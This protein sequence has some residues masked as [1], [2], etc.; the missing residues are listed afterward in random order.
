VL[1]YASAPQRHL[2]GNRSMQMIAGKLLGGTSRVSNGLYTRS[3]P[4]EFHDWGEG[5]EFENVDMLYDRSECIP[6][7]KTANGEWNTR[8]IDPFFESSEMY[9]NSCIH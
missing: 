3:L 5:W 7:K 6:H 1:K 2:F 4:A 8:I 9:F